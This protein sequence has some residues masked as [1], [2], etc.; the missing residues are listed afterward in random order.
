MLVYMHAVW[1]ILTCFAA[2]FVFGFLL[3]G[4]LGCSDLDRLGTPTSR[5]ERIFGLVDTVIFGS[6]GLLATSLAKNWSKRPEERRMVYIGLGAMT[7]M[8]PFGLF[9]I[10]TQ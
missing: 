7:S 5:E 6:L 3:A 10:C 9:A 8:L 1:I 2:I 4:V